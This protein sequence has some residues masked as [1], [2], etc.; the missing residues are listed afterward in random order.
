MSLNNGQGDSYQ[1]VPGN[2]NNNVVKSL[3]TSAALKAPEYQE[4]HKSPVMTAVEHE[5]EPE[6]NLYKGGKIQSRSFKILEQGL[7]E[8]E[9]VDSPLGNRFICSHFLTVFVFEMFGLHL[10]FLTCVSD[11]FL[12]MGNLGCVASL[13][14]EH[15]CDSIRFVFADLPL[16]GGC[17]CVGL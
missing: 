6:P 5:H 16:F 2:N 15:D 7:Q 13:E 14:Y 9:T 1:A 4:M 12:C 8:G 17:N 11:S 10:T 3:A